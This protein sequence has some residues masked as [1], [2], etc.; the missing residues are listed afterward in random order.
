VVLD[1]SASAENVHNRKHLSEDAKQI[2]L[3]VFNSLKTE[4][5]DEK[6]IIIT[7]TAELTKVPYSTAWNITHEGIKPRKTR[8]DKGKLLPLDENLDADLIRR[9]IY[10]FSRDNTI[11][12]LDITCI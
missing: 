12:T 11:P 4:Q 8:C 6:G 2:I 7:H 3:N 10:H 1:F 5:D 9:I